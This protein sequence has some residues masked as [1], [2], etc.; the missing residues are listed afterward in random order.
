MQLPTAPRRLPEGGFGAVMIALLC[1]ATRILGFSPFETHPPYWVGPPK[2]LH[3]VLSHS[4]VWNSY[5]C[6]N[7]EFK[8]DIMSSIVYSS[9]DA[10]CRKGWVTNPIDSRQTQSILWECVVTIALCTIVA[11]H[12]DIPPG[13]LK[14]WRK[15]LRKSIWIVIGL[16]L[17]EFLCMI[18]VKQYLD[19]RRLQKRC[20]RKG[21]E[22]TM[23]QAFFLNS[24][25]LGVR[26]LHKIDRSGLGEWS[27]HADG[28]IWS[29]GNPDEDV[30][31]VMQT[32]D[33]MFQALNV[34]PGDEI[35]DRSKQDWLGKIITVAQA[36]WTTCQIV[37]RPFY[38]I[39]I[40]ILEVG[41]LAYVAMAAVSYAAWWHKPYDIGTMTIINA[42][43][44]KAT[45][46]AYIHI[47][48]W[49][50]SS[51][52]SEISFRNVLSVDLPH[53]ENNEV[54][55]A[56]HWFWMLGLIF[57][58]IHC[59]AWT[60]SF[61]SV[62]ERILWHL[63]FGIMAITPAL[64]WVIFFVARKRYRWTWK[65]LLC[66]IVPLCIVYIPARMYV[67]VEYFIAFRDVPCTIYKQVYWTSYV[68]H[69]G[70]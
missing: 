22:L 18:S 58:G 39:P 48:R 70:A 67:I 40:S 56:S 5:V 50:Q 33:V 6:M 7:A 32:S 44:A 16:L 66:W 43:Q 30:E 49:S 2:V 68:G 64:F 60:Y 51:T 28:T 17:P 69:I 13:P 53:G 63:S 47:D 46:D 8:T 26:N 21:V 57:A 11:L 4:I 24:G 19:A 1:T 35:T 31:F 52:L 12:L 10:R 41:T 55:P 15:L 23:Q 61:P 36:L 20:K 45:K 3:R 37:S 27:S 34:P 38:R 62:E 9:S 42:E 59:W 14:W 25:G 54:R 65:W 29:L